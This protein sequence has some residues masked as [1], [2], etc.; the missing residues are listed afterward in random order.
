V[1]TLG[2]I[3]KI[4][5]ANAFGK[6]IKKGGTILCGCSHYSYRGFTKDTKVEFHPVNVY[7]GIRG[8]PRATCKLNTQKDKKVD[9]QHVTGCVH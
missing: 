5:I 8:I 9:W 1:A 2:Q 7:K 6:R 3:K 4:D